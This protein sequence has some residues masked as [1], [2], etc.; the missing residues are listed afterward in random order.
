MKK[1]L[2]YKLN[3]IIACF[4]KVPSKYWLYF[5]WL[6]III[7]QVPIFLGKQDHFAYNLEPYP[8]SIFYAIGAR[9][10]AEGK[11]YGLF[12][13]GEKLSI[14]TPPLYVFFLTLFAWMPSPIYFIIPNLLLIMSATYF[15]YLIFKKIAGKKNEW[16]LIPTGLV[17]YF[18][19]AMIHWFVNVAMIENLGLF[20]IILLLYFLLNINDGW[21]QIAGL[22]II[23]LLLMLS[24]YT[25]MPLMLVVLIIIA[26]KLFQ[27]KKIWAL[28]VAIVL[29]IIL[30]IIASFYNPVLMKEVLAGINGLIEGGSSPFYSFRFVP[31]NF[32]S[33]WQLL[34]GKYRVYFLWI[35]LP[36]SSFFIFGL[37][38]L[39]IILSFI[40]KNNRLNNLYILLLILSQLP[41]QMIF[42]V[43][44]SRYLLL[45]IPLCVIAIIYN[46]RVLV[47]FFRNKLLLSI[48]ILFLSFA[49][50][51]RWQYPFW[52]F[53]INNYWHH[54]SKSWSYL[55]A[56][57]L[58]NFMSD[59]PKAK[60]AS[61]MFPYYFSYLS[62]N[63]QTIYL[64]ISSNQEFYRWLPDEKAWGSTVNYDLIMK[65]PLLY[66]QSFL[67][68]DEE[69][70][71]SN[72][73]ITANK[74]LIMDYE[75]LKQKFFMEKVNYY[76][77]SGTCEIYKLALKDHLDD[78]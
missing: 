72:L 51:M 59:K 64:P 6:I 40:K 28:A 46:W 9:N 27:Q 34:L 38:F 19:H 54:T 8:D 44:D 47:S 30:F 57:T 50:H 63:E 69:V 75:R 13:Q 66:I 11:G 1:N 45:W 24:K 21:K 58:N 3:K 49:L 4:K 2:T 42:W 68:N 71:V 67:E 78:K 77:C 62:S 10:L 26:F 73:Y 52:K 25:F 17:L 48:V 70:Y 39:G 16:W 14:I 12:Y 74:N 53:I 22:F 33:L 35:S 5:S 60:M 7:I 36:M 29:A 32:K 61:A 43:F 31:R 76:D 65:D 23:G 41:L 55:G 15:L 18:S 56:K 20:L 37:Y